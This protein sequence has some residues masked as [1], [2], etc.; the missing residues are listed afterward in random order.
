MKRKGQCYVKNS[1][2]IETSLNRSATYG[3]V[4]QH[5]SEAL[6]YN[7]GQISL[8]TVGGAIIK[9]DSS[10]TLGRYMQRVHKG[11]IKLGVGT[12]DFQVTVCSMELCVQWTICNE[13]KF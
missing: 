9:E 8:F 6:S 10:W 2:P 7:E 13:Q 1:T 5:C 3:E 12:L 4:L 11:S